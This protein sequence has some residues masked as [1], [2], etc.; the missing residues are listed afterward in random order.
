MVLAELVEAGKELGQ[1]W[2]YR[3]SCQCPPAPGHF[4]DAGCIDGLSYCSGRL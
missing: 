4:T 2:V 3:G 1:G